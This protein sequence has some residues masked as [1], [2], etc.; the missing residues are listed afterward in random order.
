MIDEPLQVPLD[1]SRSPWPVA[2]VDRRRGHLDTVALSSHV[3]VSSHVAFVP[4]VAGN[5]AAGAVLRSL[6]ATPEQDNLLHV[7]DPDDDIPA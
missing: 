1:F 4:C 7:T 6:D 3:L 2:S 5:H